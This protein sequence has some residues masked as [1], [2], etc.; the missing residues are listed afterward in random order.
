M[1][2]PLIAAAIGAAGGIYAANKSA[3]SSKENNA[4][5]LA[6]AQRQEELQREFAQSGVQWKVEDARKAGIHPLYALGAQTTAYAPQSVGLSTPDTSGYQN[7]GQNLARGIAATQTPSTNQTAITEAFN[8]Q[9]LEG[10]KLD[11]DIKR[12]KLASDLTIMGGSAGPG[13]GP[14]FPSPAPSPFDYFGGVSGDAIKLKGPEFK[15]ETRRD[16][17]DINS[18]A[19]IPGAGPSVG[20]MRNN[21]GGFDPVMPPELAESLESDYGGQLAWLIRNRLLPNVGIVDKP[22]IPHGDHEEIVFNRIKQQWEVIPK[23]ETQLRFNAYSAP[24]RKGL[25]RYHGDY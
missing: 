14:G 10:L 17:A 13:G 11:N 6:N 19:Y 12:T 24:V 7:A 4:T 5:V 15:I 20:L 23:F 2:L 22:H 8:Q 21:T 16:I 25:G 9:Q 3:Q 1:V 18:P